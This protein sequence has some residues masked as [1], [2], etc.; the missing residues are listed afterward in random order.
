MWVLQ[1]LPALKGV[2]SV[3]FFSGILPRF[4]PLIGK[5]GGAASGPQGTWTLSKE[6]GPKG[7]ETRGDFMPFY[8]GAWDRVLSRL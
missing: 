8:G 6:L 7:R 3:S 4:N 5:K 1:N 2:L